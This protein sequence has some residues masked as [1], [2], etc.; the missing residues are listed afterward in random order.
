MVHMDHLIPN[1]QSIRP[2]QL[3]YGD[4]IVHQYFKLS[5]NIDFL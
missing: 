4:N 3:V 5:I 1:R 2:K